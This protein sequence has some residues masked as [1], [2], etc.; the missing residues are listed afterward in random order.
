MTG[1]NQGIGFETAKNLL[2]SPE[3][4]V[5]IGARDISKGH[6]AVKKLQ[7]D[8]AV[9]GTASTVQ[10]DVTDDASVAE[11]AKQ[12][13]A[14]HDRLD[15]L[16]N[17]AGIL[18]MVMPPSAEVYRQVLNT[19]VVGALSVTEAFLNLLHKSDEK[20]LVFISS[21]VGSISQAADKNSK[22]YGAAAFEYRSS[23]AALNMLIVLYW[24][25]LQG[26]GFRVFGADPGL[27]ATNF[28]GDPESLTARGAAT[29][30]D[31]GERIARV[32]RGDCDEHVG[33]VV[34]EYGVSPW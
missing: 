11:A 33:R 6:E 20:R 5:I 28:T 23:K 8:P 18:S 29:P 4:S 22:Y 16:I 13:A 3:Y 12:V 21:S 30:E 2:R 19:N 25:R 26:D 17:N 15:I 14:D 32:V 7:A 10:L 1:A 24:N 27:C 9:K 34:G 31:G